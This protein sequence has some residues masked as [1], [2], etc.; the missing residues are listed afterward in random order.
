MAVSTPHS[1][2]TLCMALGL[3]ATALAP[4]IGLRTAVLPKTTAFA[5]LLQHSFNIEAG[6]RFAERYKLSAAV[7]NVFDSTDN[8]ITY[9]YESQLAAEAAPI[10]DIHFHPVEP[11][12]VRVTLSTSF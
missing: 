1:P 8:D 3:A 4:T 12:A 2:F 6:Y 9:F 10:A 5:P 11:R 7:Y